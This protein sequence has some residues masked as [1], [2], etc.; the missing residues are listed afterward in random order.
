[1]DA[2]SVGGGANSWRAAHRPVAG[3]AK[4]ATDGS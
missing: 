2:L 3:C 1:M 4:P